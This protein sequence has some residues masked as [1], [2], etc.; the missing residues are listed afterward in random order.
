MKSPDSL[1]YSIGRKSDKT[2]SFFGNLISSTDY[3]SYY[4][5]HKK[6]AHFDSKLIHSNKKYSY[7]SDES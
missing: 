6:A 7:N 5:K 2:Q 3:D 4:L 1:T